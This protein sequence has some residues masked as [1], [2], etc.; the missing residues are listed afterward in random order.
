LA[1]KTSAAE[2]RPGDSRP[3]VTYPTVKL[4][5]CLLKLDEPRVMGI[6]NNTPD[7]FSGDGIGGDAERA[8]NLGMA[9]FSEGADIVD[10]GGESTRPGAEPVPAA[11]ESQR[12]VPIVERLSAFR[13]GRV[14]IDTMKPEV[15]KAALFAGA[16]MVNDVSGLRNERMIDVVA[17]HDAA[18]VIMHMLGEP[19]TMQENPT[20]KDVVEDISAFFSDRIAAAERGGVNP[21]K[22]MVDPGI[23]FGK[24]LEHNLE[25]LGRLSEFKALGRPLVIGA[26]RKS[27]IGR[28]TG[29]SADERLGGSVAAAILA[30]MHGADIIRAHDIMDT[31]S[32]LKTASAISRASKKGWQ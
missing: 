28:L 7:S 10:V 27:F 6:V 24:T 31:V 29:R 18:V 21:R 17:E 14:S 15:A 1:S 26:S 20:Y 5:A 12:V 13:P 19:R 25:I 3:A 32:A 16:T 2:R 30:V 22:I 11:L 9:M 23:G 4:G 8:V